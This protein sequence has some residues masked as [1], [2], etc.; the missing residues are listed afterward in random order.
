MP[1]TLF[2]VQ[3]EMAGILP[4]R[5]LGSPHNA[6]WQETTIMV[7]WILLFL[8]YMFSLAPILFVTFFF[9]ILVVEWSLDS[10]LHFSMESFDQEDVEVSARGEFCHLLDRLQGQ[11]QARRKTLLSTLHE[12][13]GRLRFS[14]EPLGEFDS[15][16]GTDGAKQNEINAHHRHQYEIPPLVKAEWN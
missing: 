3:D 6:D 10:S 11:K 13:F 14:S 5:F 2:I 15:H 9:W 8:G 12:G 16:D 1:A 4:E 7:T